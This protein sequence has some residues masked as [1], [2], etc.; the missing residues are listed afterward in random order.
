MR[1]HDRD[2][3]LHCC[4]LMKHRLNNIETVSP[5]FGPE[6]VVVPRCHITRNS[7]MANEVSGS[8]LLDIK[9]LFYIILSYIRTQV[10]SCKENYRKL[11]SLGLAKLAVSRI[12]YSYVIS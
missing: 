10:N 4:F 1:Q 2:D 5:V 9:P 7:Q 6:I 12:T 8:C 3:L 11:L